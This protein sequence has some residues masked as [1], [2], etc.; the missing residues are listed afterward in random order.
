VS[1]DEDVEIARCVLG[2]LAIGK[3]FDLIIAL[4]AQPKLPRAPQARKKRRYCPPCSK[5]DKAERYHTY[6][7][8]RG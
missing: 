1:R 6:G 2:A 4:R 8:P 5:A 3:L 7:C